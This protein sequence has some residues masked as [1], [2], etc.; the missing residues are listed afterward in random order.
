M[1][2]IFVFVFSALFV[3]GV[4][5]ADAQVVGLPVSGR[6]TFVMPCINGLY[7]VIASP[8]PKSVGPY[9][10]TPAVIPRLWGIVLPGYGFLGRYLPGMQCIIPPIVV[11]TKGMILE[12]GTS[13]VPSVF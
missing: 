2:Y 8:D 13:L 3:S 4:H 9:I 11:P 5:R 6:I 12:F 1:K 7:I 10:I